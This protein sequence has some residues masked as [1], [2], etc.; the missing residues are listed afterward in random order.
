[1]GKKVD[2]EWVVG[3]EVWEG[4]DVNLPQSFIAD[5]HSGSTLLVWSWSDCV[6]IPMSS[7]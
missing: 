4:W 1:M 6:I 5:S 2:G 3:R 7:A